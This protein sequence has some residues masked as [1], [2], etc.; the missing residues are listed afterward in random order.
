MVYSHDGNKPPYMSTKYIGYPLTTKVISG[1]DLLVD[2]RLHVLVEPLV[3]SKSYASQ[4]ASKNANTVSLTSQA[5][6]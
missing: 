3:I 5:P 2:L 1:V 4:L 6:L